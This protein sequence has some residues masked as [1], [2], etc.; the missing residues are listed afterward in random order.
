MGSG[1]TPLGHPEQEEM[2]LVQRCRSPLCVWLITAGCSLT[3]KRRLRQDSILTSVGFQIASLLCPAWGF[4]I[5]I[6]R[7]AQFTVSIYSVD[8][9]PKR[10]AEDTDLVL[11][12][13]C[14]E[15][16]ELS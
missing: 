2:R 7:T 10:W 16:V 13:W 8:M 1:R 14:Y 3:G 15:E 4:Q 12:L 11:N 6:L 5:Q 9:Y